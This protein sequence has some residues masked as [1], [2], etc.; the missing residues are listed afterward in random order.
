MGFREN[1]HRRAIWRADQ[2]D[3]LGELERVLATEFGR[4]GYRT[5]FAALI[6][7]QGLQ[8]VKGFS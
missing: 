5:Q 2:P 7:Q 8:S 4:R 1:L 6:G 3:P